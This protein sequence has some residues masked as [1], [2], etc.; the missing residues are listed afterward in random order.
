M[1][2]DSDF[3][4]PPWLKNP[5]A[6]TLIANLIHPPEPSVQRETLSL[7]DGDEL[8][9]AHGTAQGSDRVLILHGLEGSLRSPYAARIVNAL[10]A[11]GI[12]ASFLFHRGCNGRPNR[13]A[14]SY[15]SGDTGDLRRVIRHLTSRG[16]ERLALIGYSLGGNVTLKYLGEAPPDPAIHCAAAVSTPLLLDICARRMQR[17]FSRIYQ[18]ALLNRLKRK[19]AGKR[20]LLRRQGLEIDPAMLQ[21]F[22]AFDDAYTAPV[23]GFEHAEHYYRVSSARQYLRHIDRPTLILQARDDPFMTPE[24]LPDDE[25]LSP[26][27]RFELSDHGGHVGFIGG[28]GPMRLQPFFWLELRLLKWLRE[29]RFAPLDSQ[30]PKR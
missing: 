2:I 17:G 24:V 26:L 13:L 11:A 6:Q 20:D 29:Q 19:L 25:E 23:H 3:S 10:N 22:V 21:S 30:L 5:H 18:K 8:E 12:P 9:I 7:D 28:K 15:H 27:I 16:T 1:I 4:P 14:R